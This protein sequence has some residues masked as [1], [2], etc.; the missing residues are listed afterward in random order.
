MGTLFHVII[1]A[2]LT[3]GVVRDWVPSLATG[4]VC[5]TTTTELYWFESYISQANNNHQ[6]MKWC[7][8]LHLIKP[9]ACPAAAWGRAG[10]VARCSHPGA[11]AWTIALLG[12][13]SRHL[14]NV[15]NIIDK[16]KYIIIGVLTWILRRHI[17][18]GS[19]AC[20]RCFSPQESR[21]RQYWSRRWSPLMWAIHREGHPSSAG[22]ADARW[23]NISA[24]NLWKL[25]WP[26]EPSCGWRESGNWHS[27]RLKYIIICRHL[28]I[29]EQNQKILAAL[30]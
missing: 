25:F 12:A 15:Q 28:S 16:I 29:F 22:A 3:V 18:H 30:N 8:R 17:K 23:T 21:G 2:L 27:A 19:V 20:S 26:T 1:Y 9:G 13:L 24:R 7:C 4:P 10:G 5:S 6:G 14:D 11:S